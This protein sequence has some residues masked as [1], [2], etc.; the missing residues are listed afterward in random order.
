MMVTVLNTIQVLLCC[1]VSSVCLLA[2]SHLFIRRNKLLVCQLE[3]PRRAKL[4]K[5][6]V[7]TL[8][9]CISQRATELRGCV[10]GSHELKE[11]GKPILGL[12]IRTPS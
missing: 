12:T 9:F 4:I 2:K 1:F 11:V 5:T 3:E 8:E 7:V 6:W 10:L